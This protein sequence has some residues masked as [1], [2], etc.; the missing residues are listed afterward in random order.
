LF[1]CSDFLTCKNTTYWYSIWRLT[2]GKWC[3][4]FQDRNTTKYCE[5]YGSQP[6]WLQQKMYLYSI[7]L[8]TAPLVK[9]RQ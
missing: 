5:I 6:E 4:S 9:F 3:V 7:Q 2:C 8:R 1:W